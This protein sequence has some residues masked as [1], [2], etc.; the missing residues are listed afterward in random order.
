MPQTGSRVGSLSSATLPASDVGEPREHRLKLVYLL[1]PLPRAAR[2]DGAG[3]ARLDVGAQEKLPQPVESGPCRRHL[4]QDV[5]AVAVLRDHARDAGDLTADPS[6]PLP[7][8]LVEVGSGGSAIG[9][10]ATPPCCSRFRRKATRCYGRPV[11]LVTS[12]VP[13]ATK[14]VRRTHACPQGEARVQG[15]DLTTISPTIPASVC[16]GTVHNTG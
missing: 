4:K 15:P 9:Q 11:V 5:H 6:D 12:A 1:P 2:R 13:L 3:D 7:G 10:I 14:L 8:L 16:P